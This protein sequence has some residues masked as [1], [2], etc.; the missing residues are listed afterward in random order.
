MGSLNLNGKIFASGKPIFTADNHSFRYGDGCFET[1]RFYHGK[2]LMKDLH[3][4][5]LFSS[6]KL[7][8]FSVPAAFSPE[9]LE[10]S[11]LDL[12]K[13]NALSQLGRVRLT[14]Y[15][16][17]GFL[18]D[19]ANHYPNHVIQAWPMPKD[20]VKLNDHGLQIDFFQGARKSCD[21]L[22][23]IK[24]NNYLAYVMAAISAKERKLHDCII[25]NTHERVADTTIA[26][27][28]LVK[29]NQIST[30][31]LS[32]GC[33]AGVTRKYLLQLL[34]LN[35]I[36][37]TEKTVTTQELLHADEVFLSN[38]ISGIKWVSSCGPK[39]FRQNVV[40]QIHSLLHLSLLF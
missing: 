9:Y 40:K 39:K 38:T 4:E 8:K 26:N 20:A 18:Q 16:S 10:D 14:I 22:A 33:V 11:I 36:K 29:N 23:N 34:Q 27:I 15:R 35:G 3:F 31:A 5:R 25:L 17:D 24:S 13:K 1:I 30:P 28:F 2:L 32:E 19:P 21:E 12:C 6:I 7:L 37:I